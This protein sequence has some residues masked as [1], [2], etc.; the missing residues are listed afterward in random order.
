[1]LCQII[2][3]L[4]KLYLHFSPPELSSGLVYGLEK[5]FIL[6]SFSHLVLVSK[7]YV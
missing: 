1:M 2:V 7:P 3:L 6:F 5:K 4:L